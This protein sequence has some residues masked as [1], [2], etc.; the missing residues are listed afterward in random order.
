MAMKITVTQVAKQQLDQ[1]NADERSRVVSSLR[2][3]LPDAAISGRDPEVTLNEL[4]T[5]A[6][7]RVHT[8]GDRDPLVLY[9]VIEENNASQIVV[10]TVIDRDDY[11]AVASQALAP[12]VPVTKPARIGRELLSKINAVEA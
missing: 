12:G 2:Q 1:L 10:L 11:S 6:T 7:V 5:E 9:R 8:G 4:G 3:D